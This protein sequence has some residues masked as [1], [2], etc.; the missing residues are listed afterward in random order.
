MCFI[1]ITLYET[2]IIINSKTIVVV[3]IVCH[4]CMVIMLGLSTKYQYIHKRMCKHVANERSVRSARRLE[5]GRT[6][7]FVS[8]SVR[9]G[10]I[11]TQQKR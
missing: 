2:G 9:I 11:V 5:P 3:F 4:N 8:L 7:S 10:L 1:F 6:N